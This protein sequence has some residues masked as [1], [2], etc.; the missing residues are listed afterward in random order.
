MVNEENMEFESRNADDFC[1]FCNILNIVTDITSF[2]KWLKEYHGL[3]K[4]NELLDGYIFFLNTCLRGLID[5]I[6]L[7]NSL[8][9]EEDFT[10]V[11]ARFVGIDIYDIP[12]TCEKTI[13]MKNVW[14]KTKRIRNSTSWEEITGSINDIEDL[15]KVFEKIYESNIVPANELPKNF[16]L[17]SATVFK[18]HMYLN[19]LQ[20]GVPLA[21]MVPILKPDITEEKAE[22]SYI[23][24]TYTLQYLWYVLLGEQKFQELSIRNLH[25]A[26]EIYPQEAEDEFPWL[27]LNPLR[28]KIDKW[29]YL[30][31]FFGIIKREIIEPLEDELKKEF[32]FKI[33][34]DS[35]LFCENFDKNVIEN[36]LT[37]HTLKDPE[38]LTKTDKES[39]HKKLDSYFLWYG[40]D[41]LDNSKT[42]VFNGVPAFTSTLIGNIRRKRYLGNDDEVLVSR[43]KHP[44]G[45]V[46]GFDYS[47][48]IL[49]EAF[50]NTGIS[51]YSGWLIFLDCAT[52]YSG[53]GGSLHREAEMFIKEF[54][55][56]G[57]LKVKEIILDKNIFIEYLTD[58]SA[59]HNSNNDIYS[60]LL[61]ENDKFTFNKT[62]IKGSKSI[63][64]SSYKLSKYI[65]QSIKT[66]E[67]RF[68]GDTKG[69]FFEY[70]FFNWLVENK[71][72]AGDMIY[73]DVK[74]KNEQI[75]VY[76]E[77]E[78]YV[79]IFECKVAIHSSQKVA[80]Q[81]KNKIK[82]LNDS[83]KEIIP[84]VVV[85]SDVSDE[86][87]K[88]IKR[89]KI[90][91]CANF[92]KKIENWR[93]L[94]KN[95]D[96]N[97]KKVINSI[98][99]FENKY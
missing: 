65:I 49:I 7:E 30:D 36:Y 60:K 34:F 56:E 22:K 74:I 3:E 66:Q 82:A 75:D 44:V 85:Y 64:E 76:L 27:D 11:R 71:S 43:F 35:M 62:G 9:V 91:V 95:L 16:A 41:V 69:K 50:G 80:K 94:D 15:L 88:E 20:H 61:H 42:P 24:Y 19:D 45:G 28:S 89:E 17:N 40:V 54:V 46:K 83:K 2:E 77:N 5:T 96:K 18:T 37:K 47:Y 48:G 99:E 73:S 84:W 53:F 23:G 59:S 55:E 81:V 29:D 63:P 13:F 70:L 93:K 21:Y 25:R 38:Y 12:N 51:D 98:F 33:Q 57:S 6:I 87:K 86:K 68:I 67:D 58:K 97:S 90:R 39:A 14:E 31:T 1:S 4:Y 78:E 52:D 92:K 72:K 10:F 79:Y 26:H 8:D 32:K